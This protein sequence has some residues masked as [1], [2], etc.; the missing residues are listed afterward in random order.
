MFDVGWGP[1]S[2]A[3]MMITQWC[4]KTCGIRTSI[5]YFKLKHSYSTCILML[6]LQRQIYSINRNTCVGENV[7]QL[8]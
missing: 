3:R 8:G 1:K 5:L 4:K 7:F 2:N 6:E